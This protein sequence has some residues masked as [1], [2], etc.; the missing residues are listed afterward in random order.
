M[1]LDWNFEPPNSSEI[2]DREISLT[3]SHLLGK[4]IALLITG[5]IAAYCMPELIRN[6]RR[7]GADVIVF[8]TAKGLSYVAKDALEWCSQNRVIDNFSSEAEHLNDSKPFD[9]FI[10]APASYNT[11]NKAILGIADSVVTTAIAAAFGRMERDGIPILFAPAMNGAMHNSILTRTI[12]SLQKMGVTIIPPKQ[13]DGKNKMASLELIVASTIR[14]LNKSSLS[15]SSILITGGPIPVPIDNIR[16]ITSIFTGA[17]SLEIA[18]EAWFKGAEVELILGEGSNDA[19]EY[20]STQKVASFFEYK[21]NLFESFKRKSF[22]WGIFTAAVADFEPKSVYEG[23]LSSEVG[24]LKLDLLPTEKIIDTIRKKY[25][26]L[27]MVTFKY[28]EN[29]SHEEL[30]SIAQK[31]LSKKNGFEMI[32]ANRIE[33]FKPDGTQVAWVLS[34][35]DEPQMCVGKPVIANAI[36]DNIKHTL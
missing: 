11:L 12:I 16:I 7:E 32:V 2:G 20:L 3:G 29:I 5:S 36:L 23:K 15:G 21:K 35:N 25:P 30:I 28:E 27:K 6:F 4:R 13:I 34:H 1:T 31:R 8:I 9:V 26:A 19:P 22:D 10:V 14:A 33:E 18:K 24:K 17:L